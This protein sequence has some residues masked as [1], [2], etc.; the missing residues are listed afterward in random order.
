MKAWPQPSKKYGETVCCAGITPEGEWRR[1]F[2][3]RFRHLQ[4]EQKFKRWEL[5]EY[6]PETPNDD[7][8]CESRRLHE[9]SIKRLNKMPERERPQFFSK[10]ITKSISEAAQAG[11]SLT[12]IRPEKVKFICRKKSVEEFEAE[13]LNR[14]KAL[15]QKSL[16]D[17]DLEKLEPCPYEFKLRFFDGDGKH[18]MECADWET[19][20]AYFNFSAREGEQAAIEHLR[21]T[22]EEDYP[23]NGMV[24]ALGTQK[25]RPNQWLLLGIIR[26]NE[27]VMSDLF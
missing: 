20:A 16:L 19:A 12:L 11:K 26:L 15:A 25:K 18:E 23:R 17:D 27:P 21:K 9:N 6:I 13:N 14:S 4:G 22:Y 5:L 8:R 1:L 24:L 3:I 7:K 10:F 2:P